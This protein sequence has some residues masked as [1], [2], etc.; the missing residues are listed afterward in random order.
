MVDVKAL[1]GEPADRDLLEQLVEGQKKPTR[2]MLE[3]MVASAGWLPGQD[4]AAGPT[5]RLTISLLK[6]IDIAK[7]LTHQAGERVHLFELRL[8]APR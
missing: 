6:Q 7:E 1:T 4:G 8:C 5:A 2:Q 3:V